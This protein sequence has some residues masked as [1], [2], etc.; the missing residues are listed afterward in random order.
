MN[1]DTK[2][3]MKKYKSKALFLALLV[4]GSITVPVHGQQSWTGKLLTERA[5]QE[6]VKS[7]YDVTVSLNVNDASLDEIFRG[8]E[9]QMGLRF[10]YNLEVIQKSANRLDLNYTDAILADVLKDVASQTGLTFRQINNTIS[11]GVDKLREP[12]AEVIEEVF[13][14]TVTGRVTD[15]QTG[16]AL[17]GVNIIIEGTSIGTTS[18]V[19]GEFELEVPDLNE[20]LVFT[21]IGYERQVVVIEERSEL[22]IALQVSVIAGDEMVV[23]GY[24][25]VRRSDLT[26]S[27]AS[28]SSENFNPGESGS[29]QGLIQ[30]KLPGVRIVENSGEPGGNYSISIRGSGSINAG[31]APLWVIDGSPMPGGLRSFNPD[32]IESIEVL[33]DAS[34]TAIYGSRG[35]GGVIMVTTKKGSHTPLQVNYHGYASFNSPVN[36]IDL[37]SPDE[38][39]MV[40]NDIIDSGGGNPEDRVTN[41]GAETDWQSQIFNNDAMEQSHSLSFGG[42]LEDLNYY[43]SLNATEEDGIIRSSRFQRYG[44]RVSLNYSGSTRFNFG[45]NI[46][47]NHIKDNN[48][49]VRYGINENAGA[50]YAAM[51]F[52]PTR[53]VRNQ[54]GTFFESDQLTINNPLAL[55]DGE[56]RT[57]Q[58]NL[59][60]GNIYGEYTVIPNLIAR[61][62]TGFDI[63]NVRSDTY[64]SRLTRDGRAAGGN[65]SINENQNINHFLEGTLRYEETINDHRLNLLGGVEYQ[66]FMGSSTFMNA[67]NFP[68]DGPGSDNMGLGDQET[69]NMNSNR[70]SNSLLSAFGRVNYVFKD[71]YLFTT[72]FRVDGSTRFGEE[73]Q[74]GYFPSFA[75]AWQLG[76]EDFMQRFD[77]ITEL[78]PRVSWGQTGNQAIGNLLST[79]TFGRGGA[80]VWNDQIQVGLTPSRLANPEIR[81][82]TSQQ[83]DIGV[84][85]SLFNDR[86]RGSFDYFRQNTFDMLMAM[87]LPRETGFNSQIQNIGSIT[88]HG[89]EVELE[90]FNISQ[91]DFQW[92]SNFNFSTIR[93]EVTDLGGVSEIIS[94]S[95]GQTSQ[96]FIIREGMPL[97]SYFGYEVAGVWQEDDDFSQTQNNVQPGDLKFVDQNGDNQI[98]A[99]DRVD[100]G[101][102]F[103]DF[104]ISIGNRISYRN[105][106]LSVFLEASQGVK[107]L[108]NN[109]IDT[110]FPVQLRRNKIAEPYLNRWT[111]E[112][113]SNKY[114][115]FVNPLSQGSRLVN[116][117]TVED[118]SYIRLKNVQLSYS[119]PPQLLGEVLRS[120]QI[121]ITGTNLKTWSSYSGFDPA[122]NPGGDPNAR[123][124]F[125]AYPLVRKF[126]LGI[127]VG[128]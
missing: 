65:A 34:A 57:A 12:V 49:P 66:Q 94:G 8:L 105:F 17:P 50:V 40:I 106:Q 122:V 70:A 125:N 25:T 53:P 62:N 76:Q 14:Q 19:D 51:F 111:P 59:M 108:N 42:T 11:V 45:A 35:A 74:F 58:R 54:D 110:Y 101:N 41:T 96:I 77:F 56:S 43:I 104:T 115:S 97:R 4:I 112:N 100:L 95:A 121:Y 91:R 123:V 20:T 15:A 120:A 24:G 85:I 80:G 38:Y 16:E 23:I 107:M 68:T 5:S 124:D 6:E 78:K 47:L 39:Q 119:F 18:N 71:K 75:I 13:Q 89:F 33:K 83:F 36:N 67:Q 102:S 126:Q 114:P 27:V 63:G 98:T 72:T 88:N 116:S 37:L 2:K 10:L 92:T 60:A 73:N 86:I 118:A 128:F 30:G 1:M 55:I 46:N 28:I 7:F 103:P 48:A 69:F 32:D 79:T 87:P 21:Y 84:D 61:V 90:T 81:W 44:G 82:E 26:G 64:I 127:R 22:D 117:L 29:I 99:D 3:F 93:N 113:P 52:D 31:T 109:L 9:N